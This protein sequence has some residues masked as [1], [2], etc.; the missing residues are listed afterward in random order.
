MSAEIKGLY[1]RGKQ[2][3]IDKYY[4]G[5]RICRSVRTNNR[6]EAEAV[7]IQIMAE[8]DRSLDFKQRKKRTFTECAT[9]WLHEV[10]DKP[11]A[12]QNAYILADLM[13][14][15]GSVEIDKIHD[16]T[17]A[18]FIQHRR[19]T[20]KNR[21]INIA[22]ELII[23]ILNK[24]SKKWRDEQG[25]TWLEVAP[26]LSKL[27]EQTD[28][29]KAYPLTLEQQDYL[30]RELPEHLKHMVI[31]KV[32]TG[33]REQE[34]C[35]LKWQWEIQVPE[36]N[37]S[38]F[39]IPS[40]F[41][42]RTG[43]GGVKNKSDRLVVLNKEAKQVIEQQ[44]GKH[45]SLV[46]PYKGAMLSKMNSTSWRKA[47]IRAAEKLA[48]DKGVIVDEGFKN[49]RVHDLKHTFGY[50]LRTAGVQFEDRQVLL[51]H[52]SDSVTTDYSAPELT[53][54]IECANKVATI[55]NRQSLQLTILRRIA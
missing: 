17:L 41:G 36:I 3:Y 30:L 5:Q 54:I 48:K 28:K 7:I 12:E 19:K 38:V 31:F 16:A 13:P 34:V 21:T 18:K 8:I 51:G 20:V 50:R 52:K 25:Q 23:R 15:I 6:Q 1:K 42:G 26:S 24:A 40:N 55:K 33:C 29:R 45:R 10:K 43:K 44:R 39:L 14:F 46:F 32:N 27:D 2:W 47:R 35:Q 11:S 53:H 9:K 22:I 37:A 4:R 49:V